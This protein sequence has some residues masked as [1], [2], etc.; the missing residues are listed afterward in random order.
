MNSDVESVIQ[1]ESKFKRKMVSGYIIIKL[2]I[3]VP[4]EDNK[5][6][7]GNE[8]ITIFRRDYH[9][10]TLEFNHEKYRNLSYT[11]FDLVVFREYLDGFLKSKL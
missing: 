7:N 3:Q 4:R 5:N 2:G 10:R 1:K 8:D 11:I 9:S 6:K